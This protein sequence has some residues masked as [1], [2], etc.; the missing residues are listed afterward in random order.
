MQDSRN[1]LAE[2]GLVFD[3]VSLKRKGFELKDISFQL[4][5]GF[6]LGLAGENGAGKST[7]L[8]AIMNRKAKVQ[9]HIYVDGMD[10]FSE[11]EKAFAKIGFISDAQV[12]FEQLSVTDNVELYAPFY[13]EFDHELFREKLKEFEVSAGTSVGKLSRGQKFR[14]MLAFAMA[15]HSSLYLID[16]ATAG[17][18]LVYRKEFFKLLKRMMDESGASV[19]LVTHLKEELEMQVDYKMILAQGQVKEWSENVR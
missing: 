5:K 14:F 8:S 19:V 6:I 9:G 10:I 13:P 18:D 17:M 11:R 15:H 16:E 2:Y 12:F 3:G 4:P 7:L 1:E